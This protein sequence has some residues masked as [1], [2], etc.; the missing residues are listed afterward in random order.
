LIMTYYLSFLSNTQTQKENE[1]SDEIILLAVQV[2]NYL[3]SHEN[4]LTMA[5]ALLETALLKSPHNVYLKVS[6]MNVYCRLSASRRLWG[7]FQSLNIKHVQ[8]DSC[9]YLGMQMLADTGMYSEL[10]ALSSSILRF[11]SSTEQDSATYCTRAMTMGTLSKVHEFLVF[12]RERMSG[13]LSLLDAMNRIMDCASLLAAPEA[14]SDGKSLLGLQHG[15]VGLETDVQHATNIAKEAYNSLGAPNLIVSASSSLLCREYSDN[16]DTTVLEY[17]LLMPMVV[18]PKEDIVYTCLLRGHVHGLLLRATL[19]LEATKRPKKGKLGKATEEQLKRCTSMLNATSQTLNFIERGI[20]DQNLE[21]HVYAM[22]D[23][24]RM[25]VHVSSGLPDKSEE[26]SLDTRDERAGELIRSAAKHLQDARVPLESV[27]SVCR[28]LHSSFVP[29]F[30]LLRMAARML[31]IFGWGKQK[32]DTKASSRALAELAALLKEWVEEAKSIVTKLP[33]DP[34]E[35][36][37]RARD[38][39]KHLSNCAVV[40]PV[41]QLVCSRVVEGQHVTRERVVVFLDEMIEDLLTFE[42][43]DQQ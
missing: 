6:A 31:A 12:Q 8:L 22:L 25:L 10:V 4:D 37:S 29:H 19:C 11:H 15:I 36:E 20:I 14:S 26:N 40:E 34:E 28:H 30:A 2:M 39:A 5:A 17:Q 13:S 33:G 1:P 3:S 27:S 23:L 24:C 7:L 32:R 38:L 21:G 43:Q 18:P 9:S 16:R 35:C 42:V 41:A